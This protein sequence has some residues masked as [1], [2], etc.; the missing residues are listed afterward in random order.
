MRKLA[1]LA[2]ALALGAAAS[3]QASAGGRVA[4]GISFG[5]PLYYP[6]Y[7]APVYYAPP[8]PYYYAPRV[9]YSSPPVYVERQEAATERSVDS[10]YYCEQSKA[11]YPYVKTCPGGWQKVPP[12]PRG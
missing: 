8:P 9:V 12:T 4:V 7:P 6:H 3:E 1:F 11:Y 2:A 10:W 5:F